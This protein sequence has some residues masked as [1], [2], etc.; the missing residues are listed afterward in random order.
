[1]DVSQSNGGELFGELGKMRSLPSRAEMADYRAR[2]GARRIVPASQVKR[3][4][5]AARNMDN[6]L[7]YLSYD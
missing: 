5:C 4:N 6:S 3:C 1:M 7:F 2:I